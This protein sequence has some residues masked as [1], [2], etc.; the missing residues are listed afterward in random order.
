MFCQCL[1]SVTIDKG[2]HYFQ[3][4]WAYREYLF[5]HSF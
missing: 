3:F 5:T 4:K 2:T 1:Y